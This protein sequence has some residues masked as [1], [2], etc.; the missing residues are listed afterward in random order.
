MCGCQRTS[1]L[2]VMWGLEV[3]LRLLDLHQMYCLE[4]PE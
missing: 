1:V 3:E 2:S 4:G